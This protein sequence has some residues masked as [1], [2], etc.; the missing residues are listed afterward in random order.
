MIIQSLHDY[1]ERLSNDS[2]SGVA[3]SG[4]CSAK[5]YFAFNLSASGELLD[6]LPLYET[7]GQKKIAL[8]M[9]VP[10][11]VKKTSGINPNF[12]CDNSAYVLGLDNKGKPKRTIDSHTSFRDLHR[13]VF[14]RV[15]DEGANAIMKFLEFRESGKADEQVIQDMLEPLLE[16]GNIVFKL[17]GTNGYIHD[18]PKVKK[19]WAS[20]KEQQLGK[21]YVSQCLVT[22]ETSPI[23]LLHPSIKGVSGAQSSGASIVSFNDDAYISYNKKQSYNAPVSVNA[24]FAYTTALNYLLAS[25]R[26][27][28]QIGDATTV[29]WADRE[30]EENLIAAFFDPP[31]EDAKSEN[32]MYYSDTQKIRD[33]LLQLRDGKKP[34]NSEIDEKTHFC[35][36]GLSPNAARI[37]IRYYYE[38]EFGL[39]MENVGRHYG[40]MSIILPKDYRHPFPAIW[41]ILKEIATLGKSENIPSILSGALMRAVLSGG[42]YPRSLYTAILSRIRADQSK[43]DKTGKPINHI[44]PIRAGIIKACLMRQARIYGQKEKEKMLT[45]SLNEESS[46]QGYI[47]GRLF[48]LLERAQEQA[49]GGNLNSTIRDRYFGSASATPA[50][51]F[52]ILLRL[53]QHHISKAEYGYAID[54]QIQEV[55]NLIDGTAGFPKHL[56]LDD[57]GFFMLGY[58]QQRQAF[59]S[60]KEA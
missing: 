34:A 44:N 9:L 53:S 55:L 58:Y 51:V 27:R 37:S 42:P 19:A 14:E 6:I 50:S 28:L 24:T 46:N 21:A 60:K 30:E 5:V 17:D 2:E 36:L 52:P 56:N 48:A 45:M 18:R 29:F 26:N 39:L 31:E 43:K 54:R 59:Y 25:K 20:Y 49:S 32:S 11:Q 41:R 13:R 8:D 7:K 33:I 12:L 35:I 22:G 1:Y 15:E 40:D 3:P 57:Q 4:Y 23:A 16:G 10:E 38:G 47:L